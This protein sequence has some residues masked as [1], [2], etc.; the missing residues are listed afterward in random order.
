MYRASFT[1]RSLYHFPIYGLSSSYH[2]ICTSRFASCHLPSYYALIFTSQP[3]ISF[4][5]VL[6]MLFSYFSLIQND[7][8]VT[9]C[10]S[11]GT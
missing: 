3:R 10:V 9:C 8:W 2:A 7:S 1:A 6:L 5:F 11:S 4:Y